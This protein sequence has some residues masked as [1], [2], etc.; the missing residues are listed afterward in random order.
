MTNK[1][2][3]SQ[4][5]VLKEGQEIGPFDFY[6]VIRLIKQNKVRAMDFIRKTGD[7]SWSQVADISDF[8]LQRF[9]YLSDSVLGHRIPLSN[10]RRYERYKVSEKVLI[11]HDNINV[12]GGVSELGT[13]GAGVETVYGLLELSDMTKVH[14]KI[15]DISINAIAKVVSKRDWKNPLDNTFVFRYGLKFVQFDSK[16]EVLLNK[17]I[18]ELKINSHE[19]A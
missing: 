1:N 17:V 4:W 3:S 14:I 9:K 2:E 15:N 6:E 12:W 13:G 11:T 16:S 5:L 8:Q 7:K 18:K 19:A 10:R